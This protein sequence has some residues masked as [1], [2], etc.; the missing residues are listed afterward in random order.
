MICS[1]RAWRLLSDVKISDTHTWDKQLTSKNE[2]W[3]AAIYHPQ[4]LNSSLWR[5]YLLT[6][7]TSSPAII[8]HH[9]SY[10][11]SV[12]WEHFAHVSLL[13]TYRRSP[14]SFNF[15][16]EVLTATALGRLDGAVQS[17]SRRFCIHPRVQAHSWFSAKICLI[18]KE[19][20]RKNVGSSSLL[21]FEKTVLFCKN[22]CMESP[23]TGPPLSVEKAVEMEHGPWGE[24]YPAQRS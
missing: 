7:R 12:C 20:K 11:V 19:P 18:V 14:G 8:E 9:R 24:H 17:W 5:T 2:E 3:R 21:H 6:L 15:P 1:F 10:P 23:V 4:A 22:V 13:K 16:R